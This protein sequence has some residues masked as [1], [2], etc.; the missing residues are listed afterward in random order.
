LHEANQALR[1]AN[2]AKNEFLSRV[3]H[4]FVPR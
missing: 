4:E 1:E 2:A 3:S